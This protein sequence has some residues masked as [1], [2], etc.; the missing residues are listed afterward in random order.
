MTRARWGALAAL[1]FLLIGVGALALTASER[2]HPSPKPRLALLTSLPIVLGEDF[3]LKDNGSPALTA[4]SVQFEVVPISTTSAKDLSKERLLLL[5]QPPAQAPENLVA[6]DD[7]VRAGGRVLL[8][9]DPLLEWP[10]KRPLG[11]PLRPPPMFTDTGL[12]GHWGLRLDAP[13]QLGPAIRSLAGYR[14]V[15]VSP[16]ALHGDCEISADR[17]VADCRIGK[18]R[19]VVVADADLLNAGN[20]GAEAHDNLS[21]VTQELVE[22]ASR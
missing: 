19:A 15:T 10:S 20:L 17:L 4:L 5:A 14:I 2:A 18:G 22:V 16:G 11:D 1:L 7:W 9:A 13:D 8:L 3:G 12:L 6:L 21:A